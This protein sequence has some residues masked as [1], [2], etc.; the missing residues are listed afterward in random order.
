VSPCL[1]ERRDLRRRASVAPPILNP[2]HLRRSSQSMPPP[3]PWSREL[4][5]PVSLS[6]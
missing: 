5:Q 6:P 4:F 3:I 1:H 2:R